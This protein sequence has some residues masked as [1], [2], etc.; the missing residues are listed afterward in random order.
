MNTFA[1]FEILMQFCKKALDAAAIYKS[2]SS[3]S[4]D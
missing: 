2:D 1:I 3:D 4:R